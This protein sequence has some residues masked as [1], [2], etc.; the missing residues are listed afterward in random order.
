QPGAPSQPG[1]A[2]PL[3]APSAPSAPGALSAPGAPGHAAGSGHARPSA[4]EIGGLLQRVDALQKNEVWA[5]RGLLSPPQPLPPGLGVWTEGDFG[6]GSGASAGKLQA[7]L[8]ALGS[9]AGGGD[10]LFLGACQGGPNAG[11]GGVVLG[12]AGTWRPAA[13]PLAPS[14]PQPPALNAAAGPSLESLPLLKPGLMGYPA[15]ISGP[16]WTWAVERASDQGKGLAPLR[17]AQAPAPPVPA[18]QGGRP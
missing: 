8:A 9:G 18:G 1:A 15:L 3:S 16:S 17:A 14:A 4:P 7:D 5:I 13:G 2:G 11:Q 10:G 6:L 12:P